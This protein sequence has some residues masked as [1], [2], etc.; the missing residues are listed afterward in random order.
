MP[1]LVALAL[2]AHAEEPADSTTAPAESPAPSE[3]SAPAETPAPGVEPGEG[4]A[5]PA[6][7][8]PTAPAPSAAAK[9]VDLDTLSWKWDISAEIAWLGATDPAWN[10]F[11]EDDALVSF[12]LRAG[13]AVHPNV[14]LLVGWQH[15]ANGAV[16]S[17]PAVGGALVTDEADDLAY[18]ESSAAFRAAMYTDELSVGAKGGVTVWKW[19]HPY[20]TLK[21]VGM[22]GLVRMDDDPED[23]ENV[24][25]VEVAGVTGGFSTAAGFDILIPVRGR[26][27]VSPYV[28]LG[29]GLLAPM[30]LEDLGTVQ[31]SGFS[32]RTGMGVRF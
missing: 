23:D 18:Y 2:S 14:S 4:S 8:A 15:A 20:A 1:L 19:L 30:Q 7:P 6:A 12:G 22:R 3:P 31:F 28:E 26:W 24:T 16:S 11:A 13:Y 21:V 9:P 5:A 25:Q 27:I 29:Y 17:A 10:Y 32:G